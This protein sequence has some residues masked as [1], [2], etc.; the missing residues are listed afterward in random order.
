[1]LDAARAWDLVFPDAETF[2]QWSEER[3]R[4]VVDALKAA[5]NKTADDFL[6]VAG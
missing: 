3:Y 2:N 1:L 5:V 4:W 6:H